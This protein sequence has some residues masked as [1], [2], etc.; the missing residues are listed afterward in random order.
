MTQYIFTSYSCCVS[1][2]SWQWGS[3]LFITV[4]QAQ[5]DVRFALKSFSITASIDQG[6]SSHPLAVRSDMCHFCPFLI[7]QSKSL[8]KP[9]FREEQRNM[10]TGTRKAERYKYF[11]TGTN[12]YHWCT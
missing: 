7:Q 2:V 3:A 4:T 1:S 8:A 9:S 5:A 6:V 12:D 10:F 11:A